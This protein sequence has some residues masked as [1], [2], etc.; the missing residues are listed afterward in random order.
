MC[1]IVMKPADTTLSKKALQ[2]MWDNNPDGA[3]FMFAENGNLVIKKGMM[4][5]KAFYSAYKAAGPERK[6]VIHFRIK[7]HGAKNAEMTHPFW[8][9]QDKLGMAHN[10]V[11]SALSKEATGD[12]SDTALLARRITDAYSN[13]LLAIKHPFHQEMIESYIGYNKLVFMDGEGDTYIYNEAKGTWFEGCW[14][15][16]DGYKSNSWKKYS[17]TS[18]TSDYYSSYNNY[19]KSTSSAVGSSAEKADK[20][21]DAAFSSLLGSGTAKPGS[22]SGYG[23]GTVVKNAPPAKSDYKTPGMTGKHWWEIAHNGKNVLED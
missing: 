11:L 1:I 18:Y 15:S 22:G 3:G 6:M 5:F 14:Y 16:N 19:G 13:P 17:A 2:I 9:T 4:T 23:G 20:S 21:V 10:G 7:T 8:I 12:E